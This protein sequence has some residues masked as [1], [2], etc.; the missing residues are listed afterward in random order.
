M[1]W[2]VIHHDMYGPNAPEWVE[3]SVVA[4]KCFV[5][6]AGIISFLDKAAVDI[7]PVPSPPLATPPPTDQ[8]LVPAKAKVGPG[9]RGRPKRAKVIMVPVRVFAPGMWANLRKVSV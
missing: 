9:W 2:V 3:E 4:E 1:K 8:P 7:P 6:G 5:S